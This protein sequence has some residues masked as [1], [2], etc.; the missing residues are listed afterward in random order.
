[1]PEI[2]AQTEWLDVDAL[3]A[4]DEAQGGSAFATKIRASEESGRY[5]AERLRRERPEIARA[6]IALL[7]A[8]YGPQEVANELGIHYYSVVA[9]SSLDP[10]AVAAGKKQ[11]AR[12]AG[13]VGRRAIELFGDWMEEHAERIVKYGKSEDM[14]RI[15][16]SGAIALDK[17]Q[18]LD[19][20]PTEIREDRGPDLM[21]AAALLREMMPRDESGQLVSPAGKSGQKGLIVA[22][23]GVVA[24]A[25]ETGGGEEP[26]TVSPVPQ[27]GASDL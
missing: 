10:A 21:D 19:G 6:A 13:N 12:L 25:W 5:T 3:I 1:M 20:E 22:G 11:T 9:L 4:S 27:D 18:V 14:Q 24:A 23:R 2:P 16:T 8:G 17:A 15:V 26:K 7:R